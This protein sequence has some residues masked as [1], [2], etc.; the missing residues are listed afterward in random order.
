MTNR[1]LGHQR[2]SREFFTMS[3]ATPVGHNGLEST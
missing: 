3:D 2:E 1:F